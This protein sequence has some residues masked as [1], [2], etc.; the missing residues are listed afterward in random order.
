M[1][2]SN[3]ISFSRLFGTFFWYLHFH[4]TR[5]TIRGVRF[6]LNPFC[7]DGTIIYRKGEI[8]Y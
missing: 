4:S 8:E 3:K 6:F 7:L 2:M 1:E 5:E